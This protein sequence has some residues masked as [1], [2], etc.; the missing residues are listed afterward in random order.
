[1]Y[2][3]ILYTFEQHSHNTIP[4][5]PSC[6][7]SSSIYTVCLRITN[8]CAVFKRLLI[9]TRC[10][11]SPTVRKN[12]TKRIWI[13]IVHTLYHHAPLCACF[14]VVTDALSMWFPFLGEMKWDLPTLPLRF[15]RLTRLRRMLLF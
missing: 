5:I 11:I 2:D 12:G 13:C 15:C 4:F 8:C 10:N 7:F 14:V 9:E 6:S 3:T 1:M